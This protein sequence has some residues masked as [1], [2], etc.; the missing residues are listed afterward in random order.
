MEL[1]SAASVPAN[2]GHSY[3][4]STLSENDS[5]RLLLLQPA[6]SSSTQIRC[7]LIHTTLSACAYDIVDHYIALSYAWG[8]TTK[9][10]TIWIDDLSVNVT[11]NL[12][13]ALQDIRDKERVIRLWIDAVCIDQEN[14]DEKAVQIS[15]MPDIY[16]LARV[17]VIYLGPFDDGA[18]EMLSAP[19]SGQNH[20]MVQIAMLFL[21]KEWFRR[22]WVFQELVFSREPW[23]QYGRFRWTW[24]YIYGF[25][26]SQKPYILSDMLLLSHSDDKPWN[27][28][29][30]PEIC[31]TAYRS[32]TEISV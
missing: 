31:A 27:P 14:D 28:A 18:E 20:N 21:G 24:E 23:I 12:Y 9:P 1:V 22:V 4:Y 16:R 13:S 6:L 5:I 30:D 26:Q 15:M 25:L 32:I 11:A 3:I 17:T 2:L 10:N 7:S 19:A 8:S 29:P